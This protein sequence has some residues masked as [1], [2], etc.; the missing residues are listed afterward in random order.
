[1]KDIR[2]LDSVNDKTY[3]MPKRRIYAKRKKR[4]GS[5]AKFFDAITAV[6]G[7]G[8]QQTN[9]DPEQQELNMKLQM[10][11]RMDAQRMQRQQMSEMKRQ[12]DAQM[13]QM[14]KAQKSMMQAQSQQSQQSR[15]G[16]EG[17][18]THPQRDSGLGGIISSFGR[19]KGGQ[20]QSPMYHKKKY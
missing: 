14:R 9:Y 16:G 11:D 20:T 15:G 12:R 3:T 2:C 17:A 13:Q 18:H 4:R 6:K 19:G 10:Q 1:M 5:P 8:E 7:F